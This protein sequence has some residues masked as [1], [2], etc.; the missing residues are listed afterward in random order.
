MVAQI[1]W[2]LNYISIRKLSELEIIAKVG[3]QNMLLSLQYLL[4][5]HTHSYIPSLAK[6]NLPNFFHKGQNLVSTRC[7]LLKLPLCCL[8][9]SHIHKPE[10]N[11]LDILSLA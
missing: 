3:I 9:S 11:E 1:P 5:K 4:L 2:K 7:L 8:N 6:L 10:P